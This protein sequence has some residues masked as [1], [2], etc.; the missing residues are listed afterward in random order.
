MSFNFSRRI[1]QNNTLKNLEKSMT[2]EVVDKNKI[3]NENK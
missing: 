1:L 3:E 2:I